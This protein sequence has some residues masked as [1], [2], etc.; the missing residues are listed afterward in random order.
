[1]SNTALRQLLDGLV[2]RGMKRVFVLHDFDASGFSI[3]GTLATDSRRYTFKNQVEVIDLGL[4]LG[5]IE[6]MGLTGEKYEPAYWDK[7][8]ETLERHGA[9]EEEIHYLEHHRVE[10]NAMASD[11]FIQFLEEKLEEHGVEK[12]I[13][14][15]DVLEAHARQVMERA[16]ANK[17]LAD[18]QAKAHDEASK[19]SLADDL[20]ELVSGALED[21]PEQPWDL[22]IAKIASDTMEATEW[23]QWAT[24]VAADL[25]AL[26]EM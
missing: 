14:D 21:E 22:A 8:S 17:A 11:V 4:R 2:S 16:L 10:L 25:E 9:S 13:P 20:A 18:V 7:R 19:I 5:D 26:C 24:S 23:E 12:I 3:F 1:M 6:D 15:N